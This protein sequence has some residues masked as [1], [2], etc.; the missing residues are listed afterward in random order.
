[1]SALTAFVAWPLKRK[2][3]LAGLVGVRAGLNTP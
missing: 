2:R 3:L 1:M